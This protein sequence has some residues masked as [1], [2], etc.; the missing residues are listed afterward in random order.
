MYDI[1]RTTDHNVE[2]QETTGYRALFD[3]SYLSSSCTAARKIWL[4]S[5]VGRSCR[6]LST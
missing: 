3:R 1:H 6:Y 5:N 2:K 4:A